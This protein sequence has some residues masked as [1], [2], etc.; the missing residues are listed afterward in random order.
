MHYKNKNYIL[1]TLL[2]FNLKNLRKEKHLFDCTSPDIATNHRI[3]AFKA[4]RMLL[5]FPIYRVRQ[6]YDEHFS[7]KVYFGDFRPSEVLN[8]FTNR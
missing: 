3:G 8:A 6:V 1:V 7:F 5:Y 2:K 4:N